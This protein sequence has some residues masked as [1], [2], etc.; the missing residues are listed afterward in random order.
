MSY[1]LSANSYELFEGLVNIRF[2]V[3]RILDADRQP[4]QAVG[5]AEFGAFCIRHFLVRCG[6][7]R[8][9]DG[10]NTAQAE[11]RRDQFEIF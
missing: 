2:D 11:G 1:E 10:F 9:D 5:D 7:G 6:C 8:T 4:Q 3:L